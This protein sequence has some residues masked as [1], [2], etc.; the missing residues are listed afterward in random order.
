[1]MVSYGGDVGDWTE[2]ESARLLKPS[3]FEVKCV[4]PTVS[5]VSL[6]ERASPYHVGGAGY[7]NPRE[8]DSYD[9]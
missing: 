4:V 8:S 7:G 6:L 5:E 9:K 3:G 2:A 1:M